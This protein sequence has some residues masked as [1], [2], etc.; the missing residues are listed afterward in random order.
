MTSHCRSEASTPLNLQAASS[1]QPSTRLLTRWSAKTRARSGTKEKPMSAKT[2]TLALMNPPYESA[3][4]TTAFRIIAA[5]LKK[6]I[7]VNVFAYEGAV[8]LPFKDQTP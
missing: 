1:Y 2:L 5:A 3:N 6:K 4:S 8:F 7:N